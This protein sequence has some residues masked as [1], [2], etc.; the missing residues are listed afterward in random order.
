MF[1]RVV[2]AASN[3]AVPV[4]PRVTLSLIL[5]S[6]V[7]ILLLPRRKS[8]DT[9]LSRLSMPTDGCA[10]SCF[11]GITLGVSTL[12]VGLQQLRS[13]PLVQSISPVQFEPSSPVPHGL[14]SVEFSATLDP[15]RTAQLQFVTQ[16]RTINSVLLT[17]T[18]IQLSDIELSLGHPESIMLNEPLHLGFASYVSFYPQ[19]QIYVQTLLTVCSSE[20]EPFWS[21]WYQPQDLSI[22][23]ASKQTYSELRN[24]YWLDGDQSADDWRHQLHNIERVD[25]L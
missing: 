7:V 18:G 8:R 9:S 14:Y 6:T 24:A 23:F 5:V 20:D 22:G 21:F 25:C 13:N 4:V 3:R 12:D 1:P 17:N 15:I 10:E 19:Y 16:S 2:R 11:L